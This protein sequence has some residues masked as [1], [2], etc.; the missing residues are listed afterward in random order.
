MKKLVALSAGLALV[1][2][3]GCGAAIPPEQHGMTPE[4]RDDVRALRVVVVQMPDDTSVDCVI[5]NQV[6]RGGVSCDWERRS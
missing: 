3:T 6:N 5:I 2:L 4:E 1:A